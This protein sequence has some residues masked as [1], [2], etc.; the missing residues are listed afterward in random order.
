MQSLTLALIIPLFFVL[1]GY[2][3]ATSSGTFPKPEGKRIVFLIAHPDDEAM[4][5]APTL[6][7]LTEK[8]L[9]NHV[10]ILCLS[11]GRSG[12]VHLLQ[13]W[14]LIA[15]CL[16]DADGLGEVRKKELTE[17]AIQLGLRSPSD[18]LVIEDENFRDSMTA[19]WDKSL[20]ANLLTSAFAPKKQ[21]QSETKPPVATIDMLITFDKSGISSHPN[22]ISLYYGAREFLNTL[23]RGKKG[24]ACP[25]TMYTLAST[26]ILRKYVGVLDAPLAMVRMVLGSRS[27]KTG[28]PAPRLLYISSMMQY[29]RAQKA[30]T[31][32]HVS[33]MRWFRWGWISIGRYMV[34]NDL[35][36]ESV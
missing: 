20:I 19:T 15:L 8:S 6:L 29:R 4:F 9:G 24:W 5:F 32:A 36:R 7:A 21:P 35:K 23:M 28:A 18:V 33:Q 22:H 13:I 17:S 26:N 25:I 14:R 1:W 3:S 27:R 31:T 16:G 2:T 12:S 11:S 30:M 34:I 10:K